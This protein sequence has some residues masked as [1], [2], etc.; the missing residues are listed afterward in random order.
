[1]INMKNLTTVALATIA[2]ATSAWSQQPTPGN[3]NP[4]TREW[5]SVEGTKITAIYLGVQNTD[6]VLKLTNGRISLVPLT[7]LSSADN[8]F[9]SHNF[10]GYYPPWR[11]WSRDAGT[12]LTGLTVEQVRANAGAAV[13]TTQHFQFD[14]D[15]NLGTQLMR[16][17]AKVFELTYDLNSKSPFGIQAKPRNQWFE[18]K[19]FGTRDDYMKAGGRTGTAGIYL[20]KERVFLAPLELMGVRSGPAGWRKETDDYDPSTIVHELTHMLTHDMLDNLPT[21]MNEGYAEYISHIPIDA[22]EFRTGSDKIREGVREMFIRQYEKSRSQMTGK[23]VKLDKAGKNA[24]LTGSQLPHL[25]KVENVLQLTDEEWAK[26]RSAG[27]PPTVPNPP[28]PATRPPTPRNYYPP[29]RLE[30]PTRL[31]RLYHTAHLIM[32]YFIQIEG[33]KGVLKLQRFLDQNRSNR[34]RYEQYLKDFKTYE[35]DMEK[36]MKLPGV[37]DLGGGKFRYPTNLQPPKAPDKPFTDPTSLQLGGLPMLLD[38]ESFAT[39]GARIEKALNEHLGMN[40]SFMELP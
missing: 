26:G 25:F 22:N 9:V 21:W 2:I 38:G 3:P 14:C 1:M 6:V 28:T 34:L 20:L 7:K 19:L 27:S 4:N 37:T 15:V 13:Y 5:T 23:P 11:G 29:A 16:N 10:I 35:A 18:A 30:D 33:E 40:L 24:Y 36:F 31:P 39:A 12:S 8:S 32:Y 17:L